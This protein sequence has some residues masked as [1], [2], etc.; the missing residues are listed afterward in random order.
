MY[1]GCNGRSNA[2]YHVY[3]VGRSAPLQM[4]VELSVS[5]KVHILHI[6]T[7]YLKY[8]TNIHLKTFIEQRTKC[9]MSLL[10]HLQLI[11]M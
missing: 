11:G 6:R 8:V 9:F 1:F 4:Y 2:A 3:G 10:A 7:Y 5:H